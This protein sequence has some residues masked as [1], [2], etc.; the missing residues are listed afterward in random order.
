VATEGE[1]MISQSI[2]N[3]Y[4][5]IHPGVQA[6]VTAVYNALFD[7]LATLPQPP[8]PESP[9]AADAESPPPP[10]SLLPPDPAAPRLDPPF[11]LP[12]AVDASPLGRLRDA[13]RLTPFETALLA[14]ALL[15]ELNTRCKAIVGYLQGNPRHTQPTLYLALRLFASDDPDPLRG[16][17]ALRPGAP[18]RAWSLLDPPPADAAT[19]EYPLRL[20]RA[21]HWY[22]LGDD[23]PDPELAGLA[24]RAPTAEAAAVALP[25]VLAY[26][27]HPARRAVGAIL[28]YGA[29]AP[30]ALA[31]TLSAGRA[32]GQDLLL[33]D[34]ERLARAGEDGP[35]LLRR[36][37]REALLRGLLPCVRDAVPLLRRGAPQEEAYRG[38]LDA[39]PT[40]VLL[41]GDGGEEEAYAAGGGGLCAVALPAPDAAERLAQWRAAAAREGIAAD[42]PAL[43]VLAETTSLCG[44]ALDAAA[45]LAR[46]TA[47]GRGEQPTAAHLQRAARGALR[48]WTGSLEPTEPRY[49]WDDLVLPPLQLTLLRHLCNRVRYRS[50]VR[51]EWDLGHGT[52][53]G[54]VA[55]FAGEPGTGKSL[56]AEVVAHDLG[57]ALVKVDLSQTVSKYIGETEKNLGQLFDAAER[58][59]VALIFDEADAL[60]GKRSAVKDSHDRYANLE[61]SYLLQRLE[62]FSGLAILTTNLGANL[63]EAFTRRLAVSVDFPVP[64]P[65]DRL[66][67]WERLLARAPRDPSLDLG[68]LAERVE[69]AG[70]AIMSAAVAAGYLAAEAGGV[71]DGAHLA[72]ALRWELRKAGRLVD[73]AALD[74]LLPPS[75]RP[76]PEPP[77][78]GRGADAIIYPRHPR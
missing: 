53:P 78:W 33:L 61:T 48:D 49:S 67:L 12:P 24:R 64:G 46:A 40:P 38:V 9:A 22:L 31:V 75:E 11:A 41:L 68:L 54:V 66:R 63:D 50:R 47:E 57:L 16:V 36:G 15:P 71:I 45:D 6:A 4:R 55:L 34:G 69:L 18:L 19:I 43:R 58:L 13:L 20:E 23:A 62:R 59:G 73:S 28:L 76:A 14:L 3:P 74:A 29:A 51:E 10:L 35:R 56:A 8:D 25:E 5:S 17:H 26:L 44:P 37:L 1:G 72:Q 39:C 60:F 52:L 77:G 21:L 2:A 30:A 32:R 27:L 7:L 65:A 42:E 70:G